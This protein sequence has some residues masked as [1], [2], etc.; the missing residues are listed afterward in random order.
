AI[1]GLLPLATQGSS[2]YSPLAWVII[3]GLVSSTLIARLV[4]PVMYRLLAPN[5]EFTAEHRIPTGAT[6]G[7]MALS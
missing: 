6:A 2:L 7:G 3:G 1:G 4:T 5:L